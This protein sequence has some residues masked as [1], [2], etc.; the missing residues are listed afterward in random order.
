[1][2][3]RTRIYFKREIP[4]IYTDSGIIIPVS[5]VGTC[6][7]IANLANWVLGELAG[8]ALKTPHPLLNN[9]LLQVSSLRKLSI[10]KAGL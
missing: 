1:M 8:Q 7:E 2:I 10:R 4:L 5:S 3:V 6:R 9:K